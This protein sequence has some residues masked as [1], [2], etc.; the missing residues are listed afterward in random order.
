MSCA[1]H[2]VFSKRLFPTAAT[3]LKTNLSFNSSNQAICYTY[4]LWKRMNVNLLQLHRGR[5]HAL[6]SNVA[7]GH[8]GHGGK[9]LILS[10]RVWALIEPQDSVCLKPFVACASMVDVTDS[11]LEAGRPVL[12]GAPLVNNDLHNILQE[13]TY[14]HWYIA[15]ERL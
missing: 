4:K 12:M 1:H 6:N 10:V 8:W 9:T 5:L 13:P 11:N 15:I 14:C 2:T 7:S 3:Y